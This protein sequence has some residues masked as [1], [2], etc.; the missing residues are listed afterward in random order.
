MSM[1][2]PNPDR[3]RDFS[4]AALP[5]VLALLASRPAPLAGQ[6]DE[7]GGWMVSCASVQVDA[8][9][10]RLFFYV[11]NAV[12]TSGS[13]E[14]VPAAGERLR[15]YKDADGMTCDPGTGNGCVDITEP[16]L[17][18]V[19]SER[20]DLAAGAVTP[21]V[22][23]PG[24]WSCEDEAEGLNRARGLSEDE[25]ERCDRPV[26]AYFIVAL[27]AAAFLFGADGNDPEVV[28]P[29]GGDPQ[30][31]GGDGADEASSGSDGGGS[32][33]GGTGTGGTGTGGTGTSGTGTSGTGTGDTG[34]GGGGSA[35]G[36]SGG[37]ETGGEWPPGGGLPGGGANSTPNMG[38]VPEPI[39][40]TLF[41]IG[42]LGY[43]GA[44]LRRRRMGTELEDDA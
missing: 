11:P 40:T 27:P 12:P 37:G 17:E 26:A 22:V 4:V 1:S 28:L 10:E 8:E 7:C 32:D 5:V 14:A 42:L 35:G 20:G 34:T 31:P 6:A 2:M 19:D 44:R 13:G 29:A 36:S 38:E 25:R 43:A 24:N 16:W 30:L 18:A 3:V 15:V 9:E 39:S 41:G 21:G 33:A 23:D